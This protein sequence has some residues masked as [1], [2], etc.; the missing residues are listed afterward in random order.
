MYISFTQLYIL[1]IYMY[2][3]INK[4]NERKELRFINSKKMKIIPTVI[5][6]A[7]EVL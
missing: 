3:R 1:P 7:V 5:S 6:V 2:T 4:F